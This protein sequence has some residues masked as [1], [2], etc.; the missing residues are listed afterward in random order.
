MRIEIKCAK[1]KILKVFFKVPRSGKESRIIKC[2]ENINTIYKNVWNS[3][4]IALREKFITQN[5]SSWEN[6]EKNN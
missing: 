6:K 2:N 3:A 4:K 1:Y 5:S